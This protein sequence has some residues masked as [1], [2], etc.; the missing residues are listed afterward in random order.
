M[1]HAIAMRLFSRRAV[2]TETAVH[3][4]AAIRDFAGG[5]FRPEVFGKYEPPRKAFDPADTREA[6]QGL[7]EPQGTFLCKGA[8]QLSSEGQFGTSTIPP[9][10]FA[11]MVPEPMSLAS[12]TH[13]L[14][15][16]DV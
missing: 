9:D 2:S 7:I 14:H 12:A 4:I 16:L 8:V 3:Q 15:A 13:F 5:L 10:S 6:V 11:T 1:K